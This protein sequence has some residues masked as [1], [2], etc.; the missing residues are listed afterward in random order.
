VVRR[1]R[2]GSEGDARSHKENPNCSALHENTPQLLQYP[3]A[4]DP[5]VSRSVIKVTVRSLKS[6]S[7]RMPIDLN[8][9]VPSRTRASLG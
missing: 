7:V 6:L 9:S 5:E 2:V 8:T 3:T 1:D 4:Y